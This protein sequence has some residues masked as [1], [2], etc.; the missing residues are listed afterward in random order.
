MSEMRVPNSNRLAKLLHPNR[1]AMVISEVIPVSQSMNTYVMK[2]AD[3]HELAYFEAGA[4][5]PVFVDV[6]GNEIERPYSLSSSPKQAEEGVYTITVKKADG[7]YISNYIH[8]HWKA[9]DHVTLGGPQNGESYNSLR[10]G[11]NIVALAGGSGVTHFLSMA[12]ALVDGD[13]GCK[14][15]TL[16]YGVNTWAEVMCPEKWKELEA[17]SNGRFK[18]V[19]VVEDST[20]EADERGYITM[21]MVKK[22]CSALEDTSFYVSGPP[23]MNRAMLTALAKEGVSRKFIRQ[24]MAATRPSTA[25]RRQRRPTASPSTARARQGPFRPGPTR[26]SSPRWSRAAITRLFAAVQGAAASAAPM[27]SRATTATPISR[28]ASATPTR[29]SASSTLA[30]PIPRATSSSL[31][32]ARC[33]VSLIRKVKADARA[34]NCKTGDKDVRQ[35]P[36]KEQ[37]QQGRGNIPAHRR[38][39][40]G[41]RA[42]AQQ[43]LRLCQARDAMRGS[44]AVYELLPRDSPLRGLRGAVPGAGEGH[45]H[46]ALPQLRSE[47][48]QIRLGQRVLHR[49][50]QDQLMGG[51]RKN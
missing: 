4:Y 7:G 28:P 32:S 19:T 35:L 3:G 38:P 41:R 43:G 49:L 22:Y 20:G 10:D 36:G 25:G 46:H 40:H 23:A 47:A 8:E 6:D 50:H 42:H 31:Y 11:A 21:D 16:F 48:Y 30:A 37:C 18:L 15:L 13:V 5:I 29:R 51:T 34:C 14:T 45:I 12:Q 2:A 17:R 1:Q 44:G 39:Q 26:P 24:Y 33:D 9:G 27:S